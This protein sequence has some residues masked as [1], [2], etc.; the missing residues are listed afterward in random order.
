MSEGVLEHVNLTVS[1]PKATSDMLC[2]V[3]G[4]QVRW[5]GEAINGGYTIH[6]GGAGSYLAVYS[7]PGGNPTNKADNSYT[8][9]GGLN[10]IGVTVVDL[11]ACEARVMALG[12]KTSN[13]GDYEPGRRF[14]FH[15]AE[16]IEYEVVSYS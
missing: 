12:L 16:G 14:Y 5:Q 15:D 8:S 2:D 3:F 7:G 4:W 6:V 11:D 10:H 9:V 13:H 1:D